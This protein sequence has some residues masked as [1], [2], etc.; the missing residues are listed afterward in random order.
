M[1]RASPSKHCSGHHK[2]IE[3]KD[4]PE[5]LGKAI[6]RRNCGQR[7]SGTA[8]GRWRWQLKSTEVDGVEWSLAYAPLGATRHK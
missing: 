2:P 5:T 3:E 6:S 4:D 1:V 8:G 7:A